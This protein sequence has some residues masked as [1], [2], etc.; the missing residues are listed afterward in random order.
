MAASANTLSPENEERLDTFTVEIAEERF[1]PFEEEGEGDWRLSSNRSILIHPGAIV[2]NFS[3]QTCS[4]GVLDMLQR[5]A[6]MTPADAMRFARKWLAEHTGE[7]RLAPDDLNEETAEKREQEDA[8]RTA[9]VQ[10]MVD[11]RHSHKGTPVVPYLTSRHLQAD[12]SVVGW[13]EPA[14]P[15]GYGEMLTW[16]TDA[17]GN[18]LAIQLTRLMPDGSKAPVKWVRTT[19]RGPHNWKSHAIMRLNCDDEPETIHLVEGFEDG[20]SLVMAG[21]KNVWVLWGHW[22]LAAPRARSVPVR[23]QDH[24]RGSR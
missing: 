18:V 22:P 12:D 9:E 5:E 24:R 2:F 6:G 21:V 23:A 1:G 19:H 11:R 13:I 17:P 8:R 4:H 15:G 20:L 14:W 10:T 3:S 7:G 16:A